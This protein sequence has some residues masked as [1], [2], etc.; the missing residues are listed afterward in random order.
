M[1]FNITSS[2]MNPSSSSDAIQLREIIIF[3]RISFFKLKIIFQHADKCLLLIYYEQKEKEKS[4]TFCNQP[5]IMI[6]S[7]VNQCVRLVGLLQ[8]ELLGTLCHVIP[9]LI[10]QLQNDKSNFL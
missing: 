9:L 3:N 5:I 6:T 8:T 10:M 1:T 2:R 7:Y 4:T